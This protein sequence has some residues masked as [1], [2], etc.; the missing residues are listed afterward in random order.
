[1]GTFKRFAELFVTIEEDESDEVPAEA[2]DE[3]L[4]VAVPAARERVESGPPVGRPVAERRVREYVEDPDAGHFDE[5]A[6][7]SSPPE[8]AA[9][10]APLDAVYRAAGLPTA[11]DPGFTIFKVEK[12]L[13]SEHLAGLGDKAKAAS[14]L[15][16]LE[17]SGV[18]L[19]AV[20]QDA[21]A[22]DNAL[23]QYEAML[24]SGIDDFAMNVEIE[25]ASIEQEIAEYLEEKR[26]QVADNNAKLAEAREQYDSWRTKKQQEE[27]RIFNAVA[28][29][30]AE[31]PI[32]RDE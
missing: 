7:A 16:T 4:D 12:I 30:V 14:V 21:V 22:R 31:N 1:M 11:G 23:D 3:D 15:V 20:I 5:E 2:A 18:G 9:G 25:N 10:D 28:P 6:F 26:Q 27:E 13:H 24:R 32:T 29:F 17:A 19:T 8:P